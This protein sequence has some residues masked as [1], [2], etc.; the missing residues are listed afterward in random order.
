VTKTVRSLSAELRPVFEQWLA[1]ECRAGARLVVLEGLTKSGKTTLTKQPFAV[2]A[3]LSAN[4]ELDD[5]LKR[6]VPETTAYVDAIDRRAVDAAMRGAI[7]S[8][9]LVIV[10]GAIAWPLV[11]PV[12]TALGNNCIRRVYLKRMMRLKPDF[13]TDEDFIFDPDWWPPD[14]FHRSIYRYHAEQRPWLSADLL[15]ERIEDE[16]PSESGKDG[17]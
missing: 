6:P 3:R 1:P 13:W 15:L 14:H 7:A 17:A 12:A 8:T 9:P 10:Q 2:G 16:P 11:Q 4:V 5:F